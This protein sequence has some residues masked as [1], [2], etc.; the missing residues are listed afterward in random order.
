M[1]LTRFIFLALLFA[2]CIFSQDFI[3]EDKNKTDGSKIVGL[4]DIPV[5]FRVFQNNPNPFNPTTKIKFALPIAITYTLKVY[6]LL[7]K[8]LF[9]HSEFKDKGIY[10]YEFDGSSLSSGVYFYSIETV[11]YKEIKK[12]ILLK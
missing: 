2:S 9:T 5:V 8:E 11:S 7:G 3:G 4:K 12:M 10:E 6:D 1:K